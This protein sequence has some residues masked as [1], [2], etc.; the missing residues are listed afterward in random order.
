MVAPVS[1]STSSNG[2]DWH[3]GVLELPRSGY[4]DANEDF[5]FSGVY[6]EDGTITTEIGGPGKL[7]FS[8]TCCLGGH[9]GLM[10]VRR[11]VNLVRREAK[12]ARDRLKAQMEKEVEQSHIGWTIEQSLS[13]IPFLLCPLPRIRLLA[14]I[15][16]KT[17]LLS[18]IQRLP[19]ETQFKAMPAFTKSDMMIPRPAIPSHIVSSELFLS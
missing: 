8:S 17:A 6:I 14:V 18:G 15:M 1:V 7:C 10:F 3:L 19:T 5:Y 9:K 13:Y 12:G 16:C 2:A 4:A 11:S